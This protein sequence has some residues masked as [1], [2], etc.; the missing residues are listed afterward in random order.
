MMD[1]WITITTCPN[2]QSNSLTY[3]REVF[4]AP[5]LF[6]P[7]ASGKL[8]MLTRTTYVSC[9]ECGLVIQS[10]RMTDERIAE[11]Y[12]SGLY[13]KTMGISDAD[14]ERDELRRAKDIAGWLD[15]KI[16]Y[17]LGSH[18]DIGCSRGYLLQEFDA[19]LKFGYDENPNYEIEGV[20]TE[21][22]RENLR[23]YTLV[24]AIHVLEHTT[25]PVKE[26]AWYASHSSKYVLIEVPGENCKG[27]PLRFAH[28]YYFPPD[29]LRAMVEAAGMQV[30]HMETE[31]NTRIL[32]TVKND[33]PE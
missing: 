20:F 19:V 30:L 18:L 12:S 3:Y 24:T 6:V 17:S 2:C 4:T 1:G 25:D 11:Y 7:F 22:N 16:D 26:L 15:H 10:P 23:T 13:R 9:T 14:A 27:G 29:T 8:P 28:T 21:T 5:F 31:P 32:A 33:L